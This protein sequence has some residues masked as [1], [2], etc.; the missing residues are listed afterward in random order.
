MKEFFKKPLGIGII[1]IVVIGLI[2]LKVSLGKNKAPEYESIPVEKKDITQIVSATGRVKAAKSIDL[3]FEKSGKIA[4]INKKVGDSVKAGD[5]L[6]SL[7]S[8]QLQAELA[9]TN[10]GVLSARAQ[11]AQY[12]ASY[13]SQVAKLD[14][15]KRGTRSEEL[16]IVQTAVANAQKTVDD[17]QINLTIVKEKAENDVSHLYEEV[18]N[19]LRDAY[20]N[21]DDAINKQIDEMFINDNTSNAQL[22]FLTSDQQ[23]EIDSEWQRYLSALELEKWRNELASLPIDKP[24]LDRSLNDGIRHLTV[25]QNFLAR[26]MDSLNSAPGLTATTLASYKANVNAAR[27]NV[28]A[29]ISSINT[30]K[31]SIATQKITNQNTIS[32]AES[33]VNEAK[34]ALSSSQRELEL[35]QAGPAKEQITAQEAVVQQAR[36]NINSAKAQ[37]AQAAA[38]VASISADLSDNTLRAPIDGV[39]TK[40]ENERGEIVSPNT[41]VVSINSQ[42]QF[43]IEANVPE[44]DIAKISVGNPV[45]VTLDTYG[46]EV[47]F[48]AQIVTIDPAE[49]IVDGVSTYKTTIQFT[50]NDERIKS[51]LTADITI[52]GEKREKVLALPLR[53]IFTKENEKFVRVRDGEKVNE[54]RV[55]LGLR[56]SDG[57]VEV[58]EGVK[59]GDIVV[60]PIEKK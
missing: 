33:K 47:V 8:K 4:S 17:A 42:A 27:S 54:V 31:Q 3:A 21:A 35:K 1:A 7:E 16:L 49:T 40:V 56:G 38:Q 41:P 14:E 32:A 39:I 13:L 30:H 18:E 23:A 26:A 59:E 15:L 55:T 10:A 46:K 19:V 28:T 44:A 36:A 12:E 60:L 9:R 53:T 34:N 51:G 20:I 45:Q 2:G 24:T 58:T 29:A 22:S 48:D 37:L 6:I 52:V 43:E 57:N 5:F 50:K 11:V 25:I